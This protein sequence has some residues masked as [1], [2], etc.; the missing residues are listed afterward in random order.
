MKIDR[1][2][3]TITLTNRESRDHGYHEGPPHGVY[4]SLSE[5]RKKNLKESAQQLAKESNRHV[6]VFATR[7][8]QQAWVV[9]ACDCAGSEF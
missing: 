3:A 9:Y 2:K 7:R 1:K 8:N 5:K 6:E 4:N